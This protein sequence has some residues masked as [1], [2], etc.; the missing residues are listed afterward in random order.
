MGIL[1]TRGARH[2][3]Q[4][5]GGVGGG[6]A[7]RPLVTNYQVIIAARLMSEVN[8]ITPALGNVLLLLLLLYRD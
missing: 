8:V 3:L 1:R 7:R 2:E 5:Q 6:G 4:L